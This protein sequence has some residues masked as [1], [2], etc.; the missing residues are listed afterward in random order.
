MLRPVS[1]E[2][3]LNKTNLQIV[4]EA[5]QRMRQQDAHE[6]LIGL[7]PRLPSSPTAPATVLF[8]GRALSRIKCDKCPDSN[9]SLTQ[10]EFGVLSVTID[11][12]NIHSLEEALREHFDTKFEHPCVTCKIPTPHTKEFLI[13]ETPAILAV[14][15]KRYRVV[16]TVTAKGKDPTFVADR[17]SKKITHPFHLPLLVG[18]TTAEYELYGLVSHIGASLECGH[19]TATFVDASNSWV[20]ASDEIVVPTTVPSGDTDTYIVFYRALGP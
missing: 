2:V 7:L 13:Y 15:Y 18:D 4:S 17:I 16:A 8:N 11:E 14:Q 3:L 10:E 5:L 1:P 20:H 9:S 6:Y 12:E 19:Y